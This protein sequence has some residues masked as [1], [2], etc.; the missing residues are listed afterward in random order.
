MELVIL[1]SVPLVLSFL[2]MNACYKR[3]LLNYEQFGALLCLVPVINWICLIVY[4]YLL[5]EYELE[6]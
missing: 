1:Y 6:K 3:N 2:F 5:I 4:I